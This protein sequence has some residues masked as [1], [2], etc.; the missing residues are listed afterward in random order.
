MLE[1]S[2]LKKEAIYVVHPLDDRPEMKRDASKLGP[3]RMTRTAR[4]CLIVLRS[5]LILMGVFLAYHLIDMAG[6]LKP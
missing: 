4:W 1:K 3:I 2:A 5:Y 6:W